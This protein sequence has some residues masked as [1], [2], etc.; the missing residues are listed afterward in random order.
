MKP[1]CKEQQQ[2]VALL[3]VLISMIIVAIGLLGIAQLQIATLRQST[4]ANFSYQAA[5]QIYDMA[6]RL[7]A[8]PV[9][10][11]A[12]SYNAING[13]PGSPPSCKSS[14][15]TPTQM[16]T[17]DASDW[18]TINAAVLPTGTGTVSGAGT[19]STFR[20]TVSWVEPEVGNRSLA[21]DMNL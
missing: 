18:N 9:A 12:G 15:C 13:I 7:R 6:D 4:H 5:Q 17:Y 16:A 8:N 3:E 20:I 11:A 14:T 1:I 21:M 10:V 19:G 2:G